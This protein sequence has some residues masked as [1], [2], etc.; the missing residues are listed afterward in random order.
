M[1]GI[2]AVKV[3]I[4]CS[5]LLQLPGSLEF[6]LDILHECVS[7]GT[8]EHLEL[9]LGFLVHFEHAALLENLSRLLQVV[10]GVLLAVLNDVQSADHFVG[11][12]EV[13]APVAVQLQLEFLPTN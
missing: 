9:V 5:F 3:I 6:S 7:I 12:R 11:L 2:T 4:A 13:A 1:L 10:L 8:G